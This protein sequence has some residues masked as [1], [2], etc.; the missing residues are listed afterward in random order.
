MSNEP[1]IPGEI[2]G[3]LYSQVRRKSSS[4]SVPD[5]SRLCQEPKSDDTNKGPDQV[6]TFSEQDISEKGDNSSKGEYSSEGDSMFADILQKINNINSHFD[7]DEG[8]NDETDSAVCSENN[9]LERKT[10]HDRE[11][12]SISENIET[13]SQGTDIQVSPLEDFC[14]IVQAIDTSDHKDDGYENHTSAKSVSDQS[15]I[16]VQI[17]NQSS[18]SYD[19]T[20][21]VINQSN[22]S[23]Q[24][25]Y[26]SNTSTNFEWTNGHSHINTHLTVDPKSRDQCD[27]AIF[28]SESILEDLDGSPKALLCKIEQLR[29][30][31]VELKKTR[32]D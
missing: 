15:N 4:G 26:Q 1:K 31:L 17:F 32:Y 10:H 16:P 30:H 11:L 23:V 24:T 22:F 7:A 2:T 8:D 20:Q 3:D 5:A 9:S 6:F 28:E 19:F 21:T 18:S 12:H 25:C 14:S 27:S 29:T 13:L